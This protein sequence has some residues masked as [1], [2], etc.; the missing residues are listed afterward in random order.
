MNPK[1]FVLML[2][3]AALAGAGGWFAARHRSADGSSAPTPASTERKILFYQSAMHP[4]IKSD[5]PGRCTICGMA[6]T[7]VF[8]GEKGF[9]VGE[10]I[11]QL[12]SN[13]IQVIHVQSDAV[14]RRPLLRSLRVAGTIDDDDTRHR[15]V[16]AYI[17]GRIDKLAV[18]YVGAEVV[19]GQ[20]LATFYSPILLAAERE[21]VTL[22]KRSSAASATT[23]A[24]EH[25]LML[26]AAAQRLKRLGASDPQIAALDQKGDTDLHTEILAPMTGTVVARQVYEGQYVKEGDKLF[27]LADFSTMWFLF[28]A[29]ERDLSWIKAGL[30]VEVTTPA[31]P[32]EVFL[33]AVVFIDPNLKE[34]TRSAKVRVELGNPLVEANGQKRRK[35][36][37]KLYA[38]GAVKLEV[39]EVLAV[40]RSAVLSPGGQAVVYVDKGGGSYEQRQIKLGRLGDEFWEVLDGLSEGERI[41]TSG[42]MLIDAQAQL[43]QSVNQTGGPAPAA[44]RDKESG[45][46][47]NETQLKAAKEFLSAAAGVAQAL[48][49]DNL[50]EFNQQAVKVHTAMPAL[51]NAFGP[52]ENWRPRLQKLEAAGHLEKAAD[53]KAAR[54]EFLP[55]TASVVEFARKLRAEQPEFSSVKIYQC[56]MTD[57]AVPGAAKIGQ[58]IQAAGPLRNPFFGAEMLDCGTE[59]KP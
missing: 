55:F 2:L 53:L 34:M 48:S 50:D 49:A 57:K 22:L 24:S 32:G 39:P 12:G 15:I 38:D 33:G 14:Q 23:R 11:T 9:D 46:P 41:V 58:W 16:S 7:P 17:E 30:K 43:N 1:T 59:V 54:K 28:D 6:L 20:P 8:E 25:Q 45:G 51:L 5:Q 35:L 52:V 36:F 56:P 44:P 21:Y 29:Y 31:V 4:W 47:L 40:P 18:N 37:H 27:E 26:A 3:A 19:A 10:G 13:S 42:N